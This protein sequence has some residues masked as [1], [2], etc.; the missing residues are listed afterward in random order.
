[1]IISFPELTDW[2]L[3]QVGNNRH[4]KFFLHDKLPNDVT[5]HFPTVMFVSHPLQECWIQAWGKINE[6]H[7]ETV[8]V[9]DKS[10]HAPDHPGRFV[11]DVI[12]GAT[13]DFEIWKDEYLE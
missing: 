8:F 4:W 2:L 13:L 5:K 9:M 6:L 1:M 12:M 11:R 10:L 3:E 7:S